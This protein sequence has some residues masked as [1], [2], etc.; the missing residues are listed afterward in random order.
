MYIRTRSP[1]EGIIKLVNFEG[2]SKLVCVENSQRPNSIGAPQRMSQPMVQPII[3]L[4]P[5]LVL[6]PN[7]F[8]MRRVYRFI[9]LGIDIVDIGSTSDEIIA[10]C[11]LH[12]NATA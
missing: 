12:I 6:L 2:L 1:E 7:L 5:L 10:D 4:F 11:F 9:A 3:F 8:Q